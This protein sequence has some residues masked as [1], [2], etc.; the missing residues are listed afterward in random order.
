MMTRE[1]SLRLSAENRLAD[2]L[3]TSRE[4]VILVAPDGRIVLA[5]SSLR[6]F[7]PAIAGSL[8]SGAVF[9]DALR[10]IQSQLSVSAQSG[11]ADLSGHAEL[12]LNDGRW[13]RLTASATSD[14]GS[15]MLLSNFTLVKEREE[16]LRRATRAAEAANAAK[17][18][19]LANMSHELRTPL[20]AIIGF[21]EIVAGE[22]LGP[23]VNRKYRDYA[24]NIVESARHLLEI[25]NSVLDLAKNDAG[26]LRVADESVELNEIV[27]GCVRLVHDQ[28]ERAQL[29]LEVQPW[30]EPL[31]VN[32]DSTKLRQVLLNLLSNAIKFTEP[33]GAISV[34][35]EPV[36]AERVAVNIGDTGIG[37][38][39]EEI[40]IALAPFEQIDNKLA[41]RYQGTGL[42]L[43]LAKALVELQ[44]GD[45]AIS[46]EPGKG[47]LVRVSLRRHPPNVNDLDGAHPL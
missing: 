24:G 40:P 27:E 46:S 34:A 16:S 38:A 3:E 19:F 9:A 8:V 42:G 12:E 10:L 29:S 35:V 26:K 7:F 31:R 15:I 5:N 20:N 6:E 14:G 37:M 21:S 33:E 4:G 18:R 43:P 23:G 30:P 11:G 36:D 2:A 1:T 39:P 25:I 45:L 22:I 13:V 47:T 41:R 44:G 17:T 32:A 28:C